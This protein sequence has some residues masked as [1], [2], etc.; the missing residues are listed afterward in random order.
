[1]NC[2]EDHPTPD[3]ALD[4]CGIDARRRKSFAKALASLAASDFLE[5]VDAG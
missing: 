1:M 3:A 5:P 4:A 2:L